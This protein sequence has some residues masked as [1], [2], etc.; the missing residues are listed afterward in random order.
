MSI[1]YE[2]QIVLPSLKNSE[3]N[4]RH[5]RNL[6]LGMTALSV[7]FIGYTHDVIGAITFGS[8]ALISG[9][10]ALRSNIKQRQEAQ[11]IE[12]IE[13]RLFSETLQ[14]LDQSEQIV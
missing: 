2:K 5:S 6:Y 12:E 14:T 8:V 10:L 1:D 13:N 3:V 11:R 9:G 7:G 4:R